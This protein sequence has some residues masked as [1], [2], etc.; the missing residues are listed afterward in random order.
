MVG[1]GY[2]VDGEEV[3][4]GK[5][6]LTFKAEHLTYIGKGESVKKGFGG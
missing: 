6:V 3:G 2:G 1:R 5:R 4:L